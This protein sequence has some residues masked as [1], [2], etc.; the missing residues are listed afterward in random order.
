[1][2][3]VFSVSTEDGIEEY[4]DHY[5]GHGHLTALHNSA[6]RYHYH[7]NLYFL[8]SHPAFQIKIE[9]ALRAIDK[10]IDTPYW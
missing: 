7:G 3:I 9:R 2:E 8:T 5:I 4:G 6:G 1:M 10:K